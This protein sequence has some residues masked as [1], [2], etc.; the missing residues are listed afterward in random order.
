[1]MPELLCRLNGSTPDVGRT[2]D[3]PTRPII[4]ATAHVLGD[5]ARSAL[6]GG[7]ALRDARASASVIDG[8][9]SA[10]SVRP[11]LGSEQDPHDSLRDPWPVSGV[12]IRHFLCFLPLR[13]AGGFEPLREA[14][15]F[16][17]AVLAGGGAG[18]RG[19]DGR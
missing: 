3:A 19:V 10:D 15:S 7:A 8:R 6:C 2:A 12:A 11:H 4:G 1:M 18:E 5:P 13:G 17:F 9:A 14:L 16:Y